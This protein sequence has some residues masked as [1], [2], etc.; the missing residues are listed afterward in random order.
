MVGVMVTDGASRLLESGLSIAEWKTVDVWPPPT[1]EEDFAKEFDAYKALPKFQKS[2]P[3][4]DI[5]EF[6]L[7]YALE[8]GHVALVYALTVVTWVPL[9]VLYALPPLRIWEA[10]KMALIFALGDAQFAVH[11]YMVQ[12]G[13]LDDPHFAPY[14]LSLQLG[15]QYMFFGLVLWQILTF[16]YPKQGAGGF[17]LPKPT[18]TPKILAVF[19]GVAI[20][21]QI[22]LGG[23]VSGLHAGLSYNTFPRMDGVWAPEGVWPF[24]EWYR[25]IFEDAATAQ[26]VHRVTAYALALFLPLFWLIGRNNPH[27]AHLLPILFSI[28]VVQFLLGVLTLLF[29]VPVPL[30]LMHQANAILVFSLAVTILHR[31]FIPIK[32]IS[33]DIGIGV[34]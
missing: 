24:L 9:L 33:Y 28:F 12:N 30:A 29:V 26:F 10:M 8:Y 19:T 2:F 21:L 14:R 6:R 15:L 17:E 34:V 4:M 13:L 32:T 31:L 5:K 25:N 22:V 3:A 16:S 1:G 18:L 20:L 23:A 27:I 11:S 7:I